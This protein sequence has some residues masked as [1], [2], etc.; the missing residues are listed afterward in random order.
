MKIIVKMSLNHKN[1]K[2]LK[3]LDIL[4]EHDFTLE[5]VLKTELKKITKVHIELL[6]KAIDESED[7]TN[8][9]ACNDFIDLIFNTIESICFDNINNIYSGLTKIYERAAEKKLHEIEKRQKIYLDLIK[10]VSNKKEEL[11]INDYRNLMG[12]GDD[13][14]ESYY[15]P[16][17]LNKSYFKNLCKHYESKVDE[18]NKLSVKQYLLMIMPHLSNLINEHKDESNEWNTILNICREYINPKNI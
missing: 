17:L 8:I 11:Y 1:K 15:K 5:K 2:L 18:D 3:L 6:Q 7:I 12:D 10:L 9:N 14:V 13:Y 16:I 4:C